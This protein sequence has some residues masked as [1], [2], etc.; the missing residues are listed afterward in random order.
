M[1]GTPTTTAARDAAVTISVSVTDHSLRRNRDF[2]LLSVGQV[3]SLTGRGTATFVLPYLALAVSHLPWLFGL[4]GMLAWLPYMVL[5]IPAGVLAD[6]VSRKTLMITCEAARALLV[7]SVV[8]ALWLGSLT[9]PQL[10]VVACAE[11]VFAVVFELAEVASLPQLVGNDQANLNTASTVTSTIT[12]LGQMVG[13]ALAGA[14]MPISWLLPFATT[15]ATFCASAYSLTWLRRLVPSIRRRDAVISSPNISCLPGASDTANRGGWRSW[16]DD[17]RT[18]VAWLRRQR[19]L[20]MIAL[21]SGLA[22]LA[23]AGLPQLLTL[24]SYALGFSGGQIGFIIGAL[25]TGAFAGALA[26]PTLVRWLGFGRVYSVLS[27][28]QAVLWPMLLLIH[29]VL[30]VAALGMVAGAIDQCIS[31]AQIAYRTGRIPESLQSRVQGLFKWAV[32]LGMPL[33]TLA[34]GLLDQ[35]LGTLTPVVWIGTALLGAVGIWSLLSCSVRCAPPAIAPTP[36]SYALWARRHPWVGA[37]RTF[38][39][40]MASLSS[41]SSLPPTSGLE[42]VGGQR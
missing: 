20:R 17:T 28:L 37:T 19:T 13:P 26:E 25:G 40:D 9:V 32:Y 6:R 22:N 1:A 21:L 2:L 33:G 23:M 8:V 36:W 39:L 18:G 27:V 11:A 4:T 16:W 12:Q 7:G 42:T 38:D 15:T 30:D 10:L 41:L 34:P 14:F 29:T 31:V 5:P 24:Y 3:I 35:Q